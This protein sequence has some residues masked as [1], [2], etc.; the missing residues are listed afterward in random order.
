MRTTMTPEQ[1]LDLEQKIAH[2]VP[3]DDR[4]VGG[5]LALE[6]SSGL[7]VHG[8]MAEDPQN[9][10]TWLN[11]AYDLIPEIMT[12]KEHEGLVHVELVESVDYLSDPLVWDSLV[13]GVYF[14][15]GDHRGMYLP[16]QVKK[17]GD[18]QKVDILDRLCSWEAHVPA[19]L[20]RHPTG[21]IFAVHTKSYVF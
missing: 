9:A 17:F 4:F 21:L 20:W 7:D 16:C 8:L 13:D 11:R 15:W 1:M 12:Q 19:G 18:M 3:T 6:S 2:V 10:M 14:Q 5:Y